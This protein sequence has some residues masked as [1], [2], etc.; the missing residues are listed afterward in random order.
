MQGRTDRCDTN[1]VIWKKQFLH[2]LGNGSFNHGSLK[3]LLS[4]FS[5]S[6]ATLK[7]T[8]LRPSN[9]R[10]KTTSLIFPPSTISHWALEPFSLHKKVAEW[11]FITHCNSEMYQIFTTE[12]LWFETYLKMCSV[13]KK[14][15]LFL[16]F[17]WTERTS[18]TLVLK[19]VTDGVCT[20][21]CRERWTAVG[22]SRFCAHSGRSPKI[23][24]AR[25]TT[26]RIYRR[27]SKNLF[28]FDARTKTWH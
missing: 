27:T 15:V 13:R 10:P 4:G 3:A 20:C 17:R 8:I 24:P 2:R 22:F 1:S 6:F 7:I 5:A 26:P 21:M 12:T 19:M 18:Q 14:I 28:Y 9:S 23:F 11:R 16:A 25:S